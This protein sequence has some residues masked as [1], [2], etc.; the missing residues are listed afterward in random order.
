MVKFLCRR[1]LNAIVVHPAPRRSTGLRAGPYGSPGSNIF[2]QMQMLDESQNVEQLQQLPLLKLVPPPDN[3]R[4]SR[5][6]S[7]WLEYFHH[8]AKVWDTN[9]VPRFVPGFLEAIY[10]LSLNHYALRQSVMGLASGYHAVINQKPQFQSRRFLAQVLPDIQ[11]AI[12]NL[13]F[14]ECH[15]G[16]VFQLVK[17]YAQLGDILGA[18]R[19]LLGLGLMIDHILAGNKEPPPLVMCVYRGAIYFDIS[20]AFEGIPFALQS[21]ESNQDE[22]HRKWLANFI[23]HSQRS[24]IEFV[25]AQFELDGLEHR[26]MK[27]LLFRQSP[28]YDPDVDEPLIREAGEQILQDLQ[29]WKRR[30]IIESCEEAE[31][32]GRR[33]AS[34]TGHGRFLQYPPLIFHNEKYS[35]LLISYHSLLILATMLVHPE[36][37]PFPDTR[38]A[39][40]ITLCRILA[41]NIQKSKIEGRP[42]PIHWHTHDLLRVGLVLGEAMYPLGISFLVG[43]VDV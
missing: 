29:A 16:A 24:L 27:L 23:P 31:I 7:V 15:V 41:F 19:H 30:P 33:G 17:I 2:M 26:V 11:T 4:L 35:L 20:F 1:L 14:D 32:Q 9:S 5:N 12:S 42:G 34:T 36:I 43:V 37:G 8:L 18:H 28:E 6:D 39:S 22:I 21:P 13:T 3:M 10:N 40:A 38:F 25:L